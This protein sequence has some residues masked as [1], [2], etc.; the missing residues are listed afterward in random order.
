MPP[1]DATSGRSRPG[2][3]GRLLQ[4]RCR[5]RP[6]S[7]GARRRPTHAR[8]RWPPARRGDKKSSN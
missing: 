2:R 4:Q 6:R 1:I 3:T 7:L 8:S 5:A